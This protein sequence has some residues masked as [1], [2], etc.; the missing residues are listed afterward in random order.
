MHIGLKRNS[1]FSNET[2]FLNFAKKHFN[3]SI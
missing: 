1:V 3:F 2:Y